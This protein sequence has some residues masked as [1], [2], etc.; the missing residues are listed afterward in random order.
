MD[1]R[2][3]SSD[4]QDVDRADQADHLIQYLKY[5][6]AL[7]ETRQIKERSYE[8]LCLKEG[9]AV[10]D[11]G[12][13][14]GYDVLRMAQRVG[15]TG[16]VAGIDQSDRM[17]A[18]AREAAAG[19]LLPVSFRVG[20]ICRLDIPDAS[21]DA[22]RIE[23]TLQIV[24]TPGKVM[25]ELVRVL[26]P[27]GR[28][29]AI[30]PDWATFVIDP[31]KNKTVREFFRF[32]CEQFAGGTTGR[33]LYRY[34]RERNLRDV[35]IHPEPLVMHDLKAVL[36][37]MNMEQF[38]SAAKDRGAIPGEELDLWRHEMQIADENGCFTFTGVI[39]TVSGVK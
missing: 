39:F 14:P 30:E 26:R 36:R 35:T 6:D 3:I 25:D 13:G 22:V 27:S 28:L 31:G 5:T 33:R 4:F 15:H 10:L 34:F 17:I 24:N 16:R 37:L 2:T 1:R 19:S 18:H 11:A 21:F 38:L 32:C 23:R 9:D 8:Y 20:D 12:C 29:V 7:P